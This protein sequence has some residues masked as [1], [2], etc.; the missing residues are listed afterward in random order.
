MNDK[1]KNQG[2]GRPGG[3]PDVRNQHQKSTS[4]GS[5]A[6]VT[7]EQAKEHANRTVSDTKA[8]ASESRTTSSA[9]IH[10]SLIHI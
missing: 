2:K 8:R 4:T 10:L 7:K 9:S 5:A 3:K 1:R 6:N